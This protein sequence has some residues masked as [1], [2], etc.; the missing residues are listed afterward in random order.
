MLTVPPISFQLS[1]GYIQREAL[2]GIVDSEIEIP[3]G[4]TV[5]DSENASDVLLPG[6]DA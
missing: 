6:S 3:P 2:S 4:N 1:V 5:F